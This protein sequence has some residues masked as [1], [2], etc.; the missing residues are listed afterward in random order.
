MLISRVR[1]QRSHDS[2]TDFLHIKRTMDSTFQSEFWGVWAGNNLS[3]LNE[4]RVKTEARAKICFE[5]GRKEGGR[6]IG[7]S[8]FS[9]ESKGPG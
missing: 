9:R 6:G 7:W 1:K 4:K 3:L 8:S 5:Y 2:V